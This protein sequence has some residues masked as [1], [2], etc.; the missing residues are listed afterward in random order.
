MPDG[1]RAGGGGGPLGLGAV[2]EVVFVSGEVDV[3]L[4]LVEDP[5]DAGR[6]ARL[7][8]GEDFVGGVNIPER[9][10]VPV[11]VLAVLG[12]ER[13]LVAGE[14]EEMLAV[15]VAH[16]IR[17]HLGIVAAVDRLAV[18]VGLLEELDECARLGA[19]RGGGGKLLVDARGR[20]GD[21]GREEK[22]TKAE[23]P[24]SGETNH[25]R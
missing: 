7:V 9:A 24:E 15:E 11:D 1:V 22:G 13:A 10:E 12:G 16:V 21:E 2:G 23:A 18:V 20:R 5:V 14:E 8:D 4:Q 17:H 6:G 25:R 3:L 19:E